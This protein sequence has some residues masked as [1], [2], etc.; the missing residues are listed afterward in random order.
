MAI[1]ITWHSSGVEWICSETI[2][3][4]EVKLSDLEMF[5]DVRFCETKFILINCLEVHKVKLSDIEIRIDVTNDA[6]HSLDNEKLRFAFVVPNDSIQEIAY[7][8]VDQFR[9]KRINWE[10][11]VFR[12]RVSAINWC[13]G[14]H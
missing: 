4:D 5:E 11:K 9:S 3:F 7:F 2:T 10:V 1:S 8:Y 12:N 13:T 6:L 14:S